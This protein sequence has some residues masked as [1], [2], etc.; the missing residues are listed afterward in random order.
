[1]DTPSRDE[2]L[3]KIA[4]KRA[5]FKRSLLMYIVINLFLW[6]IWWFSSG[7][8]EGWNGFPW[9]IWVMLGWGIGIVMQYF[10]AYG[11]NREDMT[12]REYKKLKE[13]QGNH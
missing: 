8:D 13:R 3:W 12:E 6:V 10:D 1:M 7:R 9:P 2:Q 5:N 11:R 4:R